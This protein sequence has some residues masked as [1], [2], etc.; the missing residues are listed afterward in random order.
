MK[1]WEHTGIPYY[2]ALPEGCREA[3]KEDFYLNGVP[4]IGF[5]YILHSFHSGKFEVY[6]VAPGFVMEKVMPWMMYGR[7]WVKGEL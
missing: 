2:D 4:R 3:R 5:Y 6:R 7:C 1:Y